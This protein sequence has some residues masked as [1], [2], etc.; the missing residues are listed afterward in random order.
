MSEMRNPARAG[1]AAGHGKLSC[2]QADD[3]RIAPKP[4]SKQAQFGRSQLAR[5]RLRRQRL[6][7]RLHGLG[8]APLGHFL[9]EVEAGAVI[10][11]HLERYSRIDP[12]FVRALGGRDFPPPVIPI[13][14]GTS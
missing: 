6:V 8:P 9:R 10:A 11:E 2:F 4:P 5:K 1:D 13:A 3:P 7:E 14:G 12:A